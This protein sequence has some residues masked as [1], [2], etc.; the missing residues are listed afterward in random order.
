VRWRGASRSSRCPT[1]TSASAGTSMRAIPTD[2]P[3]PISTPCTSCDPCRTRRR[4]TATPSPARPSSTSPTASCFDSWWTT[5][6]ST[7]AT[8]R[9]NRT[10]GRSTCGPA[11]SPGR[12]AGGP[13]RVTG[14]GC[15]PPGWCHS[16]SGPS[17][18]SATRWRRWASLFGW[19][20]S[21][22]WWPTRT[23]RRR[24][25]TRGPRRCWNERWSARSTSPRAARP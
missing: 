19:W 2:C 6:R 10:S 14:C 13:P 17:R 3:A 23:C 11:P 5:S 4:S 9:W 21:R 24:A 8:A 12:Y 22:S 20:S 18:R 15:R 1:D 16:R 7:C 25:R